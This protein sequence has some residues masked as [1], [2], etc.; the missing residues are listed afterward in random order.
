[1]GSMNFGALKVGK[2]K[3]MKIKKDGSILR[4]NRTN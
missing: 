1:M 2:E 3:L 4:G